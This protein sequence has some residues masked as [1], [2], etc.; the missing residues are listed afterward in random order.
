MKIIKSHWTETHKAYYIE[1][2]RIRISTSRHTPR[3]RWEPV[4]ITTY[5]RCLML[6]AEAYRHI[7]AMQKALQLA[8]KL[9][10]ESRG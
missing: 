7:A 9:K 4:Y 5:G 1:P 3:H 6:P 10:E 2:H 8:Q